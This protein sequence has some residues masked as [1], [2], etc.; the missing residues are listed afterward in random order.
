MQ[1]LTMSAWNCGWLIFRGTYRVFFFFSFLPNK[2]KSS[3]FIS[4]FM[5][6]AALINVMAKSAMVVQLSLC[7]AADLKVAGLIPAVAVAF[8]KEVRTVRGLCAVHFHC[9]LKEPR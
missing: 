7:S 6:I 3:C 5:F 8:S 9:M 4:V 1:N 2:K